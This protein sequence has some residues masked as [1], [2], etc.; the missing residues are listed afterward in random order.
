MRS[1][2]SFPIP[3]LYRIERILRRCACVNVRRNA[4]VF[5]CFPKT[6]FF[7][8]RLAVTSEMTKATPV[9]RCYCFQLPVETSCTFYSYVTL[10]SILPKNLLLPSLPTS[11]S[12]VLVKLKHYQPCFPIWESHCDLHLDLTQAEGTL[13]KDWEQSLLGVIWCLTPCR[14]ISSTSTPHV[15]SSLWSLVTGLDLHLDPNELKTDNC[16]IVVRGCLDT[17]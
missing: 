5:T 9:S 7:K 10:H 2:D 14:Q 6:S 1:R 15:S 13:P 11:V 17:S 16:Q 3:L 8:S 4:R 12:L